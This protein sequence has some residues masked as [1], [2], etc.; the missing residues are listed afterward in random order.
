MKQQST[1][2]APFN[3]KGLVQRVDVASLEPGQYSYILNMTS[4][5]EGAMT[6][7]DGSVTL[8]PTLAASILQANASRRLHTIYKMRLEADN[9][10]N[11]RYLGMG[12][13]LYRLYPDGTGQY[14]ANTQLALDGTG[15][16]YL[17]KNS[18]WGATQ[19]N[20]GAQGKPST[21]FATSK[22][23]ARD[24]GSLTRLTRWGVP[25]PSKAAVCN[26]GYQAAL[27]IFLPSSGVARMAIVLNASG[28]VAINVVGTTG[29]YRVN[30]TVSSG[31]HPIPGVAI[32]AGGV[33]IIPTVVT[34][35]TGTSATGNFEAYFATTPSYGTTYYSYRVN[36]LASSGGYVSETV[37]FNA[38]P[39]NLSA[40][41]LAKNQYDSN[42]PITFTVWTDA[43]D[44]IQDI[45]IRLG[46]GEGVTPPGDQ[47]TDFY[48]HVITANS[49]QAV[50][51]NSLDPGSDASIYDAA[52][53][54]QQ[55]ADQGII[56]DYLN[57]NDPSLQQLRPSQL[58]PA[59]NSEPVFFDN[60]I[61]K[62]Q[63]L[64]VGRAGTTGFNW[65]NV[66]SV[67]LQARLA[68]GDTTT[69]FN[70]SGGN[71]YFL[72]GS[73][74]DASYGG[75]QPYDYLYCWMNP[76][77]GVM[78][79]PSPAMIEDSFVRPRLTSV[80]V[81]CRGYVSGAA[82][83]PP[84]DGVSG[85]GSL[86]LYRRGGAYS[87]G[88]YRF[89]KESAV[90][91]TTT[92]Y[93]T[94][95]DDV[96]DS[97]IIF[98]QTIE[99]DNDA[100]VTSGLPTQIRGTI[101]SYVSSPSGGPGDTIINFTVSPTNAYTANVTAGTII[102]I[103][104]GATQEQCVVYAVDSA[105]SSAM[106][107]Q[108]PTQYVHTVGEIF[109]INAVAMQPCTLTCTAFDSLFVAGDP[110]NPG[111]LYKSK[112]GKPENFPVVDDVRGT[113][114]RISVSAPSE[115]ILAIK[116]FNGDVACLTNTGIKIVK[117]WQG[118]M[119][120]PI[121]TPANRGLVATRPVAKG[122][123]K[124]YYLSTDGVYAWA[125]GECV[126]ISEA[127]NSIFNGKTVNG[128]P[129]LD[130]TQV[131]L[132]CMEFSN[133]TL[134][135]SYVATDGLYYRAVYE[136]LFD[137]W[138]INVINGP[139]NTV[140]A[141][142]SMYTEPDTGVLLS[143]RYTFNVIGYYMLLRENAIG[144]VGSTDGFTVADPTGMNGTPIS[145]R[146][147]TASFTGGDPSAQKLITQAILELSNPFADVVVESY[148]D[149]SKSPSGDTY[150]I[151]A[152]KGTITSV[153]GVTLTAASGISLTA[154]MVGAQILFDTG[155][156]RI[157]TGWTSATV[158]TLDS[159]VAL[160][161]GAAFYIVRRR[162]VPLAFGRIGSPATAQ[163]SEC[164]AVGFSFSGTGKIPTTF[165]SL[166]M[167][168][169]PL[170]EV[171]R[172]KGYDWDNLKYPYDKRLEFL[173]IE[174]NMGGRDVPM[175]LDTISG[176]DGETQNLGVMTF[177]LGGTGTGRSSAAIPLKTDAGGLPI[178]C[179]M[180]RIRPQVTTQNFQI[181]DYDITCEKYPADTTLFTEPN[182]YGTPWEKYFDQLV[183]MVD[184]GGVAASVAIY[185]DGNGSPS[186]TVSVTSTNNDRARLIT[187]QRGVQGRL[188]RLQITPG[189]GGKFQL[190]DHKF[191]FTPADKGPVVHSF[192]WSDAGYPFD[193]RFYH[194]YF[195]Y[196]VT[197]STTI[198]LEGISGV[199]G[200]QTTTSIGTLTL[201]T[202]GRKKEQFQFPVNSV[203]KLVRIIPVAS[204]GNPNTAAKIYQPEYKYEQMPADIVPYTEPQAYGSPFLKYFQQLLLDVDTGGVAATI[205]VEIDGTV[206][207]SLTVTT[208]ALDRNR[209]LTLQGNLTGRMA[210]LLNAAG[211]GTGA[212][213]QLFSH[214]FVT[215]PADK[216]PS[217]HT[218]DWSDVQHPFDKRFYHVY[219]EYEVSTSMDLVI[220]GRSGISGNQTT[221]TIATISLTGTGRKQQQFQFP[222]NSV[223]KLIR[224]RPASG[225]PPIDAKIY[226]PNYK[227]EPYPPD[228]VPYT[229]PEDSGNPYYKYYQQLVLDVDTGGVA[230]TVQVEL[231]GNVVQTL[232]VTTSALDRNRQLTLNP[233]LR[234]RKARLLN[235]AGSGGK[236]QLFGH[237]FV[238]LAADKGPVLQTFDWDDLGHPYSKRLRTVT[239]EHEIDTESAEM[240]LDVMDGNNGTVITLDALKPRITLQ[241][242]TRA[243][244]T[245]AM[246]DQ[247]YAT[248][249][250][251]HP[252][253][254]N[255][256]FKM[257]KYSFD[258]E[259]LPQNT[260]LF[261]DYDDLGYPCEKI[262]RSLILDV[263]TGNVP[264]SVGVEVDGEIKYT[265]EIQT[266][267]VDRSR[268]IAFPSDIIGFRFRLRTTPGAGGKF[269]MFKYQYDRVLE[270]CRV[271]QWDSYEQSFGSN[272]YKICKQIWFEY[273]S[274][275]DVRME[276]YCDDG[277][278]L[279]TAVMPKHDTRAVYRVPLPKLDDSGL[280]YNKSKVYRVK[281]F[282]VDDNGWF[283]LYRDS[284]R[285]ETMNTGKD[286][287]SGWSQNYLWANMPIPY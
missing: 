102:T 91:S 167:D 29:I 196:E 268:V 255:V 39:V 79:P 58:P 28:S 6:V 61:P 13:F 44:K 168:V 27:P 257:W 127:I 282:A 18:Y 261:T 256:N 73:G 226:Q 166:T 112:P 279:W 67:T 219:L 113:L 242:T 46:V 227:F 76:K 47:P 62:D 228:I 19:Y 74:P 92:D 38:T 210:R 189:S 10:L 212:K 186:Q 276:F 204:A 117:V 286:Q 274:T 110:L 32:Y 96:S 158:V 121:Q 259:N 263:D 69:V 270:P 220:E 246:P 71:F 138:A 104:A 238:T 111:T 130:Y 146:A 253:S 174:Y 66:T 284:T 88:L 57:I 7:R 241:G 119:Q 260:I 214:T 287:R 16:A 153:V 152:E 162:R 172:A 21:Y 23:N 285:I 5:Q 150:T 99:F 234:G 157:I 94:I 77:T 151:P 26:L 211:V 230:A 33:T 40:G 277:G 95:V 148:Y 251:F 154:E 139:S 222:V 190:F 30:Y 34:Q 216:G 63:W 135:L 43:P 271:S 194:L 232:S 283:K 265:F 221:T 197:A 42:D 205:Q 48:E 201:S 161:G 75:S 236:F 60:S 9:T 85:D 90:S 2:T 128:I 35:D 217:L 3:N 206:A 269:Q 89:I 199:S 159:T 84:I 59:K 231:D 51:G 70:L 264:A 12:E 248:A 133:N 64:K 225:V 247:F 78:G 118:L 65:L 235:A 125:G 83:G 24:D 72:G 120:A 145:F 108:V 137:R 184:T 4:L 207:Q 245:F 200:S 155:A 203:Y 50:T 143:G 105:S 103:G 229:E 41:G 169:A 124:L 80:I 173:S 160:S 266:S 182:D 181:F 208:T 240:I 115:P 53:A 116:E 140:D 100:P 134:Y 192:D 250:R 109:Q 165:Y 37:Y 163:G 144:T 180:V 176:I 54:R 106:Q 254:T 195:E 272:G 101:A 281:L 187:L 122:V 52:L 36:S 249:V 252:A 147:S 188:A 22:G 193:K 8:A 11:P 262:L 185:T 56:G 129:P 278:L 14:A 107:L 81:S 17:T 202:G 223:Y 142:S 97:D 82:G 267:A 86:R 15:A 141:I 258:A 218:F 275:C 20:S 87:D 123:N 244:Q 198:L 233:E 273:L 49:A 93:V 243:V 55:Y 131:D 149:Y 45:R 171:Q 68:N 191:I 114:G 224:I 237:Q 213:F 136:V 178:V 156:S 170:A 183:L 179:K 126:R 215:T 209:T 98:N 164:Y 280:V 177:T 31:V 25:R 132:S 175:V 239:I 1:I